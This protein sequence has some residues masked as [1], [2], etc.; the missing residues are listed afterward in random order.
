MDPLTVGLTAGS[1]LTGF[2]G[3]KKKKKEA[4]RVADTNRANDLKYRTDLAARQD[5]LD[6][7]NTDVA[8]QMAGREARTKETKNGLAMAILESMM[9]ETVDKNV[10]R[11][12]INAS[13]GYRPINYTAPPPNLV[14]PSMEE[15]DPNTGGTWDAFSKVFGGLASASA[16]D[17]AAKAA[18]KE[19]DE[20]LDKLLNKDKNKGLWMPSAGMDFLG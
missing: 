5:L 3:G 19:K 13:G 15:V 7:S 9:P 2:F 14:A 20:L 18:S 16:E 17:N 1:L 12:A 8:N 6:K 11:N 4:K 10:A